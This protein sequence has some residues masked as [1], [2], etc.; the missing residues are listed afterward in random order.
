M[1][2]KGAMRGST[3]IFPA[4][5]KLRMEQLWSDICTNEFDEFS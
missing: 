2:G 1:K 4:D 5:N 3:H